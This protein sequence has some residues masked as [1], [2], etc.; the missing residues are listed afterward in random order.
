MKFPGVFQNVPRH[1][2]PVDII[3]QTLLEIILGAYTPL[4]TDL[5]ELTTL[6]A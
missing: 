6:R 2:S 4:K 3:K 1:L 5:L